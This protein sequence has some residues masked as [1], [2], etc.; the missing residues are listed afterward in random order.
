MVGNYGGKRIKKV[1][2]DLI[3]ARSGNPINLALVSSEVTF[4]AK[5]TYPYNFSLLVANSGHGKEA[6]GSFEL[7][8]YST[9]P[10]MTL[11]P[12]P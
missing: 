5:I 12:L 8:V 2:K 4:D 6:E 3:I 7:V 1:E 10:R 9:D 11:R